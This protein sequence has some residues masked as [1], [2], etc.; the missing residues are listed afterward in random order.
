MNATA[1]LAE[2]DTTDDRI[3]ISLGKGVAYLKVIERI[4][5]DDGSG[6]DPHG[7]SCLGRR[8][9]DTFRLRLGPFG[10][11]MG[12][13]VAGEGLGAAEETVMRANRWPPGGD[14]EDVLRFFRLRAMR[15]ASAHS[16]IA[17]TGTSSCISRNC[18]NARLAAPGCASIN[19]AS[20]RSDLTLA[21]P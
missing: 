7:N 3:E 21:R 6:Q 14:A 2:R 1:L 15:R 12:R 5:P 18:F 20:G 16:A 4:G 11:G 17:K 9:R 10:R 8:C 13:I 19:R